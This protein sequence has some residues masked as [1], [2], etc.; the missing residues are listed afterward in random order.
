MA[1]PKSWDYTSIAA[2][3]RDGVCA[4]QTPAAGTV[5][6]ALTIA[7]ALASGGVATM[8]VARHIG[9]YSGSDISARVFTITGT[10]R[11]GRAISDTVTGVNNSTVATQRNFATVTGV[12]VDLDTGAAV[13]VGTTG[14]LDTPWYAQNRFDGDAPTG[15]GADVTA[16]ASLTWGA[17]TTM[18][19][20]RTWDGVVARDS[21]AHGTVTNK[22]ATF[23]GSQDFPV[24]GIRFAITSYVSGGATFH[25]RPPR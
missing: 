7:G 20:I 6:Q 8:D 5:D 1:R 16:A 3:D 14:S 19:P 4:S 25:V 21:A 13:E 15:I 10:D 2:L 17:E 23:F 24:S 9:V 12:T 11:Y 22:T 18:D